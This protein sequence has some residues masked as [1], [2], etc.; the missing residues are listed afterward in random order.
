MRGKARAPGALTVVNAIATLKGS[1]FAIDLYTTAEVE[2]SEDKDVIEG[3]TDHDEEVDTSL[4]E[5]CVE[6]VLERFDVD[7]GGHV[8]TTSE[9]P[10]A[11]GLKSSSAAANATVLATLDALDALENEMSVGDR[12]EATKMGVEAARDTGVTIT[13]ALDDAAASMLGGVVVTDNS[14]DEILKHEEIDWDAAVYIPDDKAPSSD[15]DVERSRLVAHVID[16]ALDLALEGDYA[17][18]MTING[19][20]YA[21]ALGYDTSI[22]IDALGFGKGAG[23]S[24]TGPSYGVIENN[25]HTNEVLK[26][27]ENLPGEVIRVETTNEGASVIPTKE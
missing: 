19:L 18:A 4:I 20:A 26:E 27:W 15:T 23:L 1:A 13:G 14:E 10:V 25:K 6:R 3:E 9:I 8:K 11:S 7:A 24:G 12:I 2:I 16:V 21:S 17:R 22:I 5:R